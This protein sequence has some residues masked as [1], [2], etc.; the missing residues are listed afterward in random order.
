MKAALMRRPIRTLIH[1]DFIIPRS[2]PIGSSLKAEP[3]PGFATVTDTG[4]KMSI[5]GSQLLTTSNTVSGSDPKLAWPD[6]GSRPGLAI[7]FRP[8]CS[9]TAATTT[10]FGVANIWFQMTSGTP[11]LKSGSLD[12]VIGQRIA[13]VAYAIVI[14]PLG[15]KLFCGGAFSS[16]GVIAAQPVLGR[17]PAAW[18]LMWVYRGAIDSA[19]WLSGNTTATFS[20]DS[21]AV[22]DLGAGHPL[23]TS[24]GIAQ[25]RIVNPA[26]GASFQ[27]AAEASLIEFRWTAATG[28][29]AEIQFRIQD[30]NNKYI[31]R[32]SQ[33]GSTIKFIRVDAGAETEL[34]SQAA[35]FSNGVSYRIS[36]KLTAST[37]YYFID[38]SATNNV[39]T[40]ATS[41]LSSTG[42]LIQGFATASE[43][44]VWPL[45]VTGFFPVGV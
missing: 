21:V 18:V 26:S 24:Y 19:A 11:K 32:M 23:A 44:T 36:L 10:N 17:P 42:C 34:R 7:V 15:A 27:A 35:T 37:T 43:L 28:E 33:G 12:F 3:G 14:D 4:S 16:P 2:A 45:D 31:L 8:R 39:S 30:A 41:F 5:S 9:T 20:P 6:Q 29:T 40:G 13:N 38:N 25:E 22:H 1:D